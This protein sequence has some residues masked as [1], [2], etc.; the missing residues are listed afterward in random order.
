M[1]YPRLVDVTNGWPDDRRLR[2]HLAGPLLLQDADGRELTPRGKKAQGILALLATSPRLRRTRSWLQDKLW[3]DRA[4]E[5]GAAS[6][7]QCLSEIR[8][9]LGEHVECLQ[10]DRGWVGLDP[11]RIEVCLDEP[12]PGCGET[13]FLEGLDISDR[14]F[15]NWI[16]DQ[17]HV[18]AERFDR[19]GESAAAEVRPDRRSVAAESPIVSSV[20]P[21][22]A[23]S[24][25]TAEAS[26]RGAVADLALDLTAQKLLARAPVAV[27]D[28]RAEPPGHAPTASTWILTA[29]SSTCGRRA[30]VALSLSETG[31]HVVL[32][33][34][35]ETSD[36][37]ECYQSGPTR[38]GRLADHAVD[39]VLSCCRP[40]QPARG[41]SS[42]ARRPS[43]PS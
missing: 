21:R 14:E 23:L 29:T 37:A 11:D 31:S 20:P 4:P 39:A 42:E 2:L 43:R 27:L 41:E 13:E 22:V 5:Q 33:T 19:P 7:R 34:E 35:I 15:E 32:W 10:A 8:R 26:A 9:S 12:G 40:P 30:R 24:L 28:L 25:R 36:L 18:Y 6:L 17:R 38:V 16:R 1:G 3:S